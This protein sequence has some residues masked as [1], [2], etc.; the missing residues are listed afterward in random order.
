MTHLFAPAVQRLIEL[1]A[2]YRLIEHVKS[3]RFR[4]FA[5]NETPA[6]PFRLPRLASTR[7]FAQGAQPPADRA[8]SSPRVPEPI[9]TAAPEP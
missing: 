9:R 5:R 7:S 4:G 2:S 6:E 8:T 3:W 1:D